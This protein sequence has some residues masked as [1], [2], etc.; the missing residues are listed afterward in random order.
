M[1][2][3]TSIPVFLPEEL[4]LPLPTIPLEL[5]ED[6]LP[7]RLLPVTGKLIALATEAISATMN[8]AVTSFL[9]SS[10]LQSENLAPAV[11]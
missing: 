11:H 8:A 5:G 9:I 10:P 6:L 4:Q 7:W 3:E 2:Q 1:F